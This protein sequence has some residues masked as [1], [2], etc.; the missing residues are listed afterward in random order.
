MRSRH[1]ER[2]A[3]A[4]LAPLLLVA[5]AGCAAKGGG[6]GPA[7][8]LPRDSSGAYA[9]GQPANRGRASLASRVTLQDIERAGDMNL[10]AF[11]ESRFTGVRVSQRGGDVS[12]FISG[13]SFGAG[14]GALVLIDGSEG[15][16]GSLTLRDVAS[17]EVLKDSAASVYGVRG[18]NGV[19]LVT[20]RKR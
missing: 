16:L 3:L 1:Q 2:I 19:L 11:I 20:T 12:V 17:I 18:A 13:A 9:A 5:G 15:S 14:T 8:L 6:G 7:P 4:L 10:G